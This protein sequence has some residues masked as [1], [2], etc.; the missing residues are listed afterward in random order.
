MA[1][2]ALILFALFFSHTALANDCMAIRGAFEIGAHKTKIKVAKLDTCKNKLSNILVEESREIHFLENE[3]LDGKANEQLIVSAAREIHRMKSLADDFK[4]ETWAAMATTEFAKLK[5]SEQ[6]SETLEK[7]LNLPV[8]IIDDD[9]EARMG[10]YAALNTSEKSKEDL[11]VLDLDGD[12][13]KL[14]AFDVKS[15]SVITYKNVFSSA[16]AKDI[17]YKIIQGKDTTNSQRVNWDPNPVSYPHAVR[18]LDFY[19][20]RI[21]IELFEEQDLDSS[22]FLFSDVQYK[23]SFELIGIGNLISKSIER[24]TGEQAGQISAIGLESRISDF[25]EKSTKELGE[26]SFVTDLLL[27]TSFFQIYTRKRTQPVR[28]GNVDKIDGLLI[29]PELIH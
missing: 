1:M 27:V 14:S 6:L 4:V 18:F 8:K 22:M 5:N 23:E 24:A 25:L 13:A 29:N 12:Y 21:L 2:K 15:D 19:P 9:L 11:L 16:H 10:F 28:F 20:R 3:K 7:E 17:M 26:K